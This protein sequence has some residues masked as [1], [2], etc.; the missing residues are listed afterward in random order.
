MRKY[1]EW[2]H[3]HDQEIG[4]FDLVADLFLYFALKPSTFKLATST[5]C[6]RPQYLQT[7]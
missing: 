1:S 6:S 7:P 2:I 4:L 3:G 5:L